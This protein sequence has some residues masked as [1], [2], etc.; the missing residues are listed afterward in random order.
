M[1]SRAVSALVAALF[2]AG[3]GLAG[4]VTGKALGRWHFFDREEDPVL[5]WVTV[6]I[7]VG[8]GTYCLVLFRRF[9]RTSN[10]HWRGP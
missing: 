9:L 5:Y 4:L 7:W 2:F 1:N 8:A 3:L 6:T 10:N